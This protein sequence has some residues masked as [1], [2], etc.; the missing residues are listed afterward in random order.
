MAKT[1]GGGKSELMDTLIVYHW[2]QMFAGFDR[3]P[4]S[5]QWIGDIN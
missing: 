1:R 2:N 5:I 4:A 3:D